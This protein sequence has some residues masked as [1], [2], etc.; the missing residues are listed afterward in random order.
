MAAALLTAVIP[1]VLIAAQAPEAA[2]APDGEYVSFSPVGGGFT[3]A[4]NGKAA[5]LFVDGG[6]HAGVVRVVGDLRDDVKRVT[7]V[8]PTVSTTVPT[9]GEPV[10]VGT[11]GRSA[12]IDRLVSNG[13]LD[14]EGIRGKWETSLQQVVNNPLPGVRRALVI[15]GSD[16]RGTIF[17]V[18]DLSRRI[19]VSPWHYFDDVP[20]RKHSAV[21]VRPGRHT[22]GTPAV[23][24]RGVF[25]NDENPSTGNWAPRTFGP[26][27][28]PGFPYGLNHKYY[29]KVFEAMLRLKANYLWPTVWGRAFA[30]DDPQNH[31]TASRYG[32]VMGT[33]HEAPMMRGIEEWVRH[34]KPDTDPYGGNGDWSY[35]TNKAALQQYWRDGV[36]R[37][38]QEDFEGVVTLGMRGDGDRP[39]PDAGRDV[40]E[41]IIA[42]QRRI[43]DEETTKPI[44]EI[45]QVFTLYKEVQQYWDAG[46][47]P[48][49]DVTVVFAD[50]NWGNMRKVPDASLPPRAG[51]YGLYYHFDY[52]GGGRNYKWVDTI[53]LANTREQLNLSYK[54]GID[55]LWVVNVGD[56]K[57]EEAPTQFFLDYAW[58]PSSIPA[59][60]ID[61]WTRKYAAQNFGNQAAPGIAEVLH[62]YGQLQARRKPEATNRRYNRNANGTYGTDDAMTPYSIENYGE[63]D[64]VTAEWRELAAKAEA[65]NQTLPT[66]D[67]DAY[68]Q[69]VLYATKATA[70]MYE[71]RRAQFVNRW[72][73][74]QGR[75]ATND[76]AA[77]AEARLADDVAMSNHYNTTLAGGKWTGW[78]TQT[79]FG[80]GDKARY[81]NNASWQEPPAPDQ[82]YP[83]LQRIT[84]PTTA[85]MGVAIDGSL[86]WWPNTTDQPVLPEFSPYQTSP[87]QHI[88][89]FNRGT[90]PF[91]YRIT[92]SVPWL[93]ATDT[94]G[95]VTQQARATLRVDWTKAPTGKTTV[96][97][98]VTGAG[99]TVTVQAVVNKPTEVP[100][101]GFVEANGYVSIEADHYTQAVNANGVSWSHIP[102]IGR[103]GSGMQ[104]NPVTAP[105]QTPG[106]DGPRLEYK[107][108]LTTTGPVTVWAYL[109]PRNN[110][111]PG[112]GVKYAMSID[113][114]AP[115]TVNITTA[116]RADDTTMNKGWEV[117]ALE[118]VN[119][120][121]TTFNVTSPGVHTLKF[122]V[123]DPTVVLQNLVVDTGGLKYSYLGP[124]ES[125]RA[126]TPSSPTSIAPE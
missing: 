32:V 91:D 104:P 117:N 28:A 44:T 4:A 95:T 84:V 64:R 50:D 49:D 38:E 59:D 76:L 106:G 98:T 110:V 77:T 93:T 14:V 52:V 30:E 35:T 3:L 68:Y 7:D 16:Q 12:L 97:I 112:D 108:N 99:R 70:N 72:Y 61:D 43:L 121:A 82:I 26:G 58:N 48:P 88:E 111:R 102:D 100:A 101:D 125:H 51:G 57:N 19:G 63:L 22:Q 34:A 80:Y 120:T 25:I 31:A 113:D 66:A 21:Y 2:A 29:E 65:V 54:S 1:P 123:V 5:P 62:S 41:Q 9:S 92:P 118:A 105:N 119:R 60:G 94:A 8:Q 116:T 10:L 78:Q 17:G 42:D 33:S 45:P 71:L 115:Q 109:S 46:M 18:Y 37:M 55:R 53:N 86:N 20:A 81:G 107:V 67:R 69:L 24:Y 126:G 79:K 73:A 6:D 11:I 40:M 15:A 83:A 103:T 13:K 87:A 114:Q 74:T 27:L 23:K 90:T 85:E 39:N 75:A 89:V 47:R 36:K 124:P 122:W 56:L 96:P